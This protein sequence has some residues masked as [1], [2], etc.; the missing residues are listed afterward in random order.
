MLLQE[1]E[2]WLQ[3]QLP[4]ML[5]PQSYNNDLKMKVLLL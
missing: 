5:N 4:D 2:M 3:I 1:L